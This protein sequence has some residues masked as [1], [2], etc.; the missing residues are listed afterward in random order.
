MSISSSWGHSLLAVQVTAS[1]LQQINCSLPVT[2]IFAHPTLRQLTSHI[3]TTQP[4]VAWQSLV[5]IKT[6]GDGKPLFLVHPITGDVSYVYQLSPYLSDHQSLYGLRAVGLDGI[7][8]PLRSIEAVAAH[9]IELIIQKQPIGPYSIGGFSLGGVIAFEMARQLKS[10]GLAVKLVALI[11]SYPL[12]PAADNHT[13]Y[14]IR[15][16]L[17][18]YYHYWSSL[19]KAP[20]VL[21]PMLRQKVPWVSQ[22][23]ARR[24]WQ[25]LSGKADS[26]VSMATEVD[27]AAP[28]S[29]MMRSLRE[30][31]SQY[32]F[33]PYEGNVV[34]LR[35]TKEATFGTGRVNVDFGWRRYARQGVEVHQ[36]VG[37]HESLFGDTATVAR[38]GQILQSYL[39]P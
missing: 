26:A 30:A 33:K 8:E 14:P 6:T 24:F 9:Y 5:P 39:T 21:I 11:D 19:P 23:L 38:I 32:E 2:S 29:R 10:R 15:Q 25:S 34:F 13:K 27:I 22:Y 16:L 35:A 4:E 18:Y 7:T 1:M 31:Y 3:Q 20:S 17:G 28:Q 37:Q 36:L 12:N